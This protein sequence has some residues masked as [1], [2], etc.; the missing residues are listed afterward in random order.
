MKT[1]EAAQRRKKRLLWHHCDMCCLKLEAAARGA[2]LK[3]EDSYHDLE[4]M[5]AV[6]VFRLVVVCGV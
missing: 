3:E 2:S 5:A 6:W 4:A 1:A